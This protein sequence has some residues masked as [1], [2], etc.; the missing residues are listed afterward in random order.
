LVEKGRAGSKDLEAYYESQLDEIRAARSKIQER[1]QV[2]KGLSAED[3]MTYY[4]S[5]IY[6]AIHILSAIPAYQETAELARVVQL[7]VAKLK[8][9]LEFLEGAGLVVRE[10]QRYRIGSARI[11]LGADSPIIQRHHANWRMRAIHSID[12]G[13][14]DELHYS[15]I[16]AI[17]RKDGARIR[18]EILKLLETIEPV[19]QASPEEAAFCLGMD[20]FEL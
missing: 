11:H 17:S 19:V 5:W 20:W 3:Q 6:A 15:S 18:E 16:F 4:S 13:N 2:K 12:R 14:T 8:H 7:P 1:I 10:G 9:Y